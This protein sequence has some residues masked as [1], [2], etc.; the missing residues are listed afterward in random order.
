[1]PF[2]KE[3]TGRTHTIEHA[4]GLSAPSGS[5]S[6]VGWNDCAAHEANRVG[7][8]TKHEFGCVFRLSDACRR[9]C[10]VHVLE[11]A[12]IVKTPVISEILAILDVSALPRIGNGPKLNANFLISSTT[13]YFDD[14]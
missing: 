1:M 3:G 6:P 11:L 12:L 9:T 14:T 5:V 7:G 2:T 13:Q 4:S 10:S 8:E